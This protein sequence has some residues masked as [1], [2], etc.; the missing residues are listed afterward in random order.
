MDLGNLTFNEAMHQI[1]KLKCLCAHYHATDRATCIMQL[2]SG[3]LQAAH[4]AAGTGAGAGGHQ[5]D[6]E[7]DSPQGLGWEAKTKPRQ[8]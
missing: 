7:V 5:W 4:S 3:S 8:I 1:Q 6:W 2:N